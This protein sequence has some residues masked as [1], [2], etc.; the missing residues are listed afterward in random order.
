VI[1]EKK[2]HPSLVDRVIESV[3]EAIAAGRFRPGTKITEDQ[4]AEE[5]GVS[6]T[7]V[8]EAV[9]RLAALGLVVVR[10]RC[11]LE[12]AT[13]DESDLAEITQLREELESFAL[14]LA[15]ARMTPGE[16]AELEE[17][18]RDCERLLEEGERLAIFR[19]D[20][21][22]HLAVAG[23]SG[24]RYLLESLQRLEMKV[25]LC[26]ALF[27]RSD[28]KVRG[29]VRFHR[30]ILAALEKGQAERAEELMREHV[31]RTAKEK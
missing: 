5:F 17:L 9:K 4:L 24:N 26:R 29:S 3:F 1:V 30:K 22:F 25:Q 27:C 7:P 16:L 10:P 20:G 6:R 19:A 13:I 21:R 31:N 14:R 11:G 8:R 28:A 23:F 15:A 2:T 18:Q 12:V